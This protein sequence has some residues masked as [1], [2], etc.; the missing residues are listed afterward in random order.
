MVS[1]NSEDPGKCSQFLQNRAA[2]ILTN[3]TTFNSRPNTFRCVVHSS[4][5]DLNNNN[6]TL[7][8]IPALIMLMIVSQMLYL[9]QTM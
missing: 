5:H 7:I 3:K 4:F 6:N 2:S 8:P 9:G 1:C